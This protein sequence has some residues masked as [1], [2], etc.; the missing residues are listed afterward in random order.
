MM[1]SDRRFTPLSSST[2]ERMVV[3]H[4]A[5]KQPVPAVQPEEPD[6]LD[7]ETR[8]TYQMLKEKNPKQKLPAIALLKKLKKQGLI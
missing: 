2:I 4:T 7:G 1:F 3:Q 6:E 5:V 8:I